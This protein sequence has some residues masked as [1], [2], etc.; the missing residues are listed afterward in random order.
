LLRNGQCGLH[1]VQRERK[2][3]LPAQLHRGQQKLFVRIGAAK[4]LLQRR[5]E[6]H[7]PLKLLKRRARPARR[8]CARTDSLLAN[9]ARAF[10]CA[11]GRFFRSLRGI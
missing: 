3:L 1:L 11:L 2:P 9:G 7:Q 10:G 4:N 8:P 5:I 6:N